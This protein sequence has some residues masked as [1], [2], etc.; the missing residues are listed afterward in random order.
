VPVVKSLY[1]S[2]DP[3]LDGVREQAAENLWK[4]KQ[5]GDGEYYIMRSFIICLSQIMLF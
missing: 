5:H 2:L 3:A 1:L 4:R